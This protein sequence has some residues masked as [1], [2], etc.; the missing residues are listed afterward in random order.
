M[1]QQS[2]LGSTMGSMNTFKN[3]MK[4]IEKKLY[5]PYIDKVFNFKDVKA[6]HRRMED[7]KQFGKIILT[8]K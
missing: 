7:R 3:V 4:K 5:A 1:K 2:I 6:A 8:P